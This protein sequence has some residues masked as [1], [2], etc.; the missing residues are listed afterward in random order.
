[1][2]LKQQLTL[3]G[4]ALAT[5]LATFPLHAAIEQHPPSVLLENATTPLATF[6]SEIWENLQRKEVP[7]GSRG[8]PNQPTVCAIVPGTL[9][10]QETEAVSPLQVWGLNPVFVWQGKWSRLEVFRSRDHEVL[11]S[12]DLAPETRYLVYSDVED[13]IPLEPGGSYYWKLSRDGSDDQEATFGE[14]SFRILDE[15]KQ[16]ELGAEIAAIGT[17]EQALSERVNFFAEQ[18]L[19]A[20]VIRELYMVDELPADLEALKDAIA[21][22]DFCAPHREISLVHQQSMLQ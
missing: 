18:E 1:M 21:S 2:K 4:A 11:L 13:A 19:W 8:N 15:A 20:D 7:G 5:T 9:F 17:S 10:D 3:L 14:T 6:W 22:H 16:L 12:Q